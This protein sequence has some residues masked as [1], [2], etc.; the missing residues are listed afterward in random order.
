MHTRVNDRRG[1]LSETI[2]L[3]AR[4]SAPPPPPT[5]MHTH[6]REDTLARMLPSPCLSHAH[7]CTNTHTHQTHTRR[8]TCAPSALLHVLS[9]MHVN[10]RRALKSNRSLRSRNMQLLVEA[11]SKDARCAHLQ[12]LLTAALGKIDHLKAAC[13]D[14][15]K[16]R[17]SLAHSQVCGPHLSPKR[18][19]GYTGTPV[20]REACS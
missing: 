16:L 8:Y 15:H 7:T 19:N 6:D 11:K 5:R 1:L 17:T 4:C 9:H 12:T 18:T 10:T 3:R 20:H 13:N 14:I 2:H